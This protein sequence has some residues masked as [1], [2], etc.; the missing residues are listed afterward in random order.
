MGEKP[1]QNQLDGGLES[2]TDQTHLGLLQ[3]RNHQKGKLGIDKEGPDRSWIRLWDSG[4]THNNCRIALFDS[5]VD[6]DSQK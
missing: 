4:R 5:E 1:K 3:G 6:C 2:M